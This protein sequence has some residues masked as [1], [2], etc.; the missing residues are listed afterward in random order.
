MYLPGHTIDLASA[1]G[2]PGASQ[3]TPASDA[4]A[5]FWGETDTLG[6]AN[7]ATAGA[8]PN[9][10][11]GAG[12]FVV[13]AGSPQYK[14]N[15]LNGY[16][17]V[18]VSGPTSYYQVPA[19][20]KDNGTLAFLIKCLAA[21]DTN[22]AFNRNAASTRLR[23]ASP[24]YDFFSNSVGGAV[25]VASG[26]LLSWSTVIIK[27]TGQAMKIRVNGT[28]RASFTVHG[29]WVGAARVFSL[30]PSMSAQFAAFG[31]F[32]AEKTDGEAAQLEAYLRAKYNHYAA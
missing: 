3:Y 6:L 27:W 23:M 9:A 12:T 4:G 26:T 22:D 29:N 21:V 13:A 11:A 1:Q 24:G 17:V 25:A 16:G 20:Q 10:S 14:T 30:A 8:I 31:L 15:I 18:Q 2:R 7:N 32:N 5:Y 19:V 28:Q